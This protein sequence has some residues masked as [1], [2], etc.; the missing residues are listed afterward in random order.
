M[1]QLNTVWVSTAGCIAFFLN[2][3]NNLAYAF[4][5]DSGGT[6][7]EHTIL[8]KGEQT[9]F[10][11]QYSK[12]WPHRWPSGL[13]KDVI[14]IGSASNEIVTTVLLKAEWII[15]QEGY[16]PHPI[17]ARAF[18]QKG[19]QEIATL[20]IKVLEAYTKPTTSAVEGLSIQV[21]PSG[22][23]VV[24][25]ERPYDFLVDEIPFDIHGDV[26]G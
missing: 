23:K 15:T 16:D 22:I 18:N 5:E 7:S 6:W 11:I 25:W 21:M 17:L 9:G 19:R 3:E 2:A 26:S 12:W 4:T 13:P 8:V 10:D 24:T 20:H 14:V 1:N